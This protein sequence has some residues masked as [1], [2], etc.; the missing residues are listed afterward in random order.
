MGESN[1]SGIGFFS[2]LGL[3]FIGLKLTE[4]ID[5]SWW[6]VLSP[7]WGPLV[8]IALILVVGALLVL[9]GKHAEKKL[10]RIRSKR[11]GRS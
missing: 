7:F 6:W 10:E 9:W 2:L 8:F 4:V 1:T 5:W 11:G 3:L